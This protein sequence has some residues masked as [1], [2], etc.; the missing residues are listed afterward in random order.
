M[1]RIIA[2]AAAMAV[3]ATPVMSQGTI[4]ANPNDYVIK[5]DEKT[6]VHFRNCTEARAAGYSRMRAGQ[7]GYARHLDRDNDD[8]ACE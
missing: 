2:L 4:K 6:D 7:P 3:F 1:R 5:P 8:I